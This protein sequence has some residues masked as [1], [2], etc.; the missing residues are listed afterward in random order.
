MHNTSQSRKVNSV[1]DSTSSKQKVEWCLPGTGVWG[2][3]MG[4]CFCF[5]RWKKSGCEYVSILTKLW[6]QNGSHNEF[7]VYFTIKKIFSE[8]SLIHF[9]SVQLLSHVWLFATPWIAA[10]QASVHYQLPEF[11][12]THA[13][14]VSD[15]IQPSHPLSSP[16]P[17]APN[18]S[19]HQ[20]LFQQVNSSHEVAKVLEFQLQHQSFQWTP[21]LITSQLELGQCFV[22]KGSLFKSS[23]MES[24]S[25]RNF[26]R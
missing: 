24:L 18:P 17:P 10:R 15:T 13:H 25:G 14:R 8:P 9:S 21:S 7:Y 16:S 26:A 23:G 1:C 4:S 3:K 2:E 5:A 20:G 6:F 12:H 22:Q 11:T 19:Q